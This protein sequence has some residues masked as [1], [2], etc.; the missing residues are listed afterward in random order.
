MIIKICGMRDADNI[1]AVSELGVDMLGFD[2]R[3]ESPRFVRMVSSLAGT[4]PDYSE[5]QI[6]R[7][8][9]VPVASPS[10]TPMKIGVFAD[11]MPQSIVTRVY[12]YQLDGVQLNGSEGRVMIENLKRTLEP[13]IRQGVRTIKTLTISEMYNYSSNKNPMEMVPSFGFGLDEDD[14]CMLEIPEFQ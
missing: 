1:R 3:P 2:F 9:S 8:A 6:T 4:I 5:E 12:N 13:D 10:V 11:D 7:N 14:D